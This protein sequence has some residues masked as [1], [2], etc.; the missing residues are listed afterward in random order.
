[1]VNVNKVIRDGKVAVLFSPEYGAGWSSWAP[2]NALEFMLFD[3]SLVEAAERK[4]SLEEVTAIVHSMFSNCPY[5]GGWEN[6]RIEWLPV[7]TVFGIEE[8]DG[9]ESVITEKCLPFTA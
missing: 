4:A 7:G 1:M 2:D 6:I 9:H 3:Q 5:T 8:Y